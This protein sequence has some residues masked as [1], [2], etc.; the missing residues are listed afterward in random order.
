MKLMNKILTNEDKKI[1]KH[2]IIVSLILSIIATIPTFFLD[3]WKFGFGIS[4][5]IGS[6]S[7]IISYLNLVFVT[8]K[9]TSFEF[10]NPKK[11]FVIN[12]MLNLIIYA[13]AL[14]LTV[15]IDVFNIFLCL[16]GI[17]ILKLVI[18]INCGLIKK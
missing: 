17:L 4:I 2:A 5:L 15:L 8:Y 16:V 9:V 13:L 10:D 3:W 7:S 14:I 12:N 1:L 18:V 11:S 6:L